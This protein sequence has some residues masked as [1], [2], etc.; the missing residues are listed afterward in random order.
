MFDSVR[1]FF[2]KGRGHEAGARRHHPKW[3]EKSQRR[4][5]GDRLLSASTFA[6]HVHVALDVKVHADAKPTT[7]TLSMKKVGPCYAPRARVDGG[8]AYASIP[9]ASNPS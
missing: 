3:D 1:D 5:L 7:T 6:G 4:S 2:W 9:Q 8:V